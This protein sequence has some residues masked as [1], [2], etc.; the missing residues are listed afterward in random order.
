MMGREALRLDLRDGCADEGRKGEELA[1]DENVID[2]V[3]K[4]KSESYDASESQ[5]KSQT[6]A[7]LGEGKM[8]RLPAETGRKCG[9]PTA[10]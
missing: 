7:G 5:A 8:Q 6:T 3:D 9:A 2:A 1:N 10:K 4:L